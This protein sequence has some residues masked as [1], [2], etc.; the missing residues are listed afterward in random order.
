MSAV[1]SYILFTEF[2]ASV[3]V[4][5]IEPVASIKIIVL[6]GFSFSSIMTPSLIETKYLDISA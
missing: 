1:R 6:T 2:F 3:S 5:L 4:E